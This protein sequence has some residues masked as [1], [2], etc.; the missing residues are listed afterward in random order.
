MNFFFL[1]LASLIVTCLGI[2]LDNDK[3]YNHVSDE[4]HHKLRGINSISKFNAFMISYKSVV[5]DVAKP[6][7][8]VLNLEK[9][10]RKC[11]DL[12]KPLL[13]LEQIIESRHENH[14]CGRAYIDRLVDFHFRYIT[15]KEASDDDDE[16]SRLNQK[17]SGS[18]Y[19]AYIFNLY[20][21]EVALTCKKRL[22]ERIRAL[23]DQKDCS[24][25]LY[26]F[27]PSMFTQSV[28]E[29][30]SEADMSGLANFLREF[31]RVENFAPIIK[32]KSA[33]VP[34]AHYDA[35]I[36]EGAVN[37]IEQLKEICKVRQPHYLA[38]FSPISRLAQ[39]GY[40][41]DENSSDSEDME[42]ADTRLLKC[43]LATAQL[44][45]GIL[46]THLI[47]K[48]NDE[49]NDELAANSKFVS[50]KW[51]PESKDDTVDDE[52]TS[53]TE[54][55]DSVDEIAPEVVERVNKHFTAA[56]KIKRKVWSW[57]KSFVE[58]HI[59]MEAMQT[60]ANEQFLDAL[61]AVDNGIDTKVAFSGRKFDDKRYNPL[62]ALS[63]YT[64]TV[65][66]MTASFWN[67]EIGLLASSVIGVT[68]SAVFVWFSIY[69]ATSAVKQHY[70]DPKDDANFKEYWRQLRN[71]RMEKV[72]SKVK[73]GKKFVPTP[74]VYKPI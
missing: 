33:H 74:T 15:K 17:I 25:V 58:R 19:I 7:K 9:R 73:K 28:S 22:I 41:M 69:A 8:G 1:Y 2:E 70:I 6:K 3:N 32:S 16:E 49:N 4:C 62:S 50:I 27:M 30:G 43:W 18:S 31:K 21:R 42:N 55:L 57:T 10:V 63:G 64:D 24:E 40:T 48:N 71:E 13:D 29:T 39:L 36:P 14:V 26:S 11:Y 53:S 60:E 46:R 5:R 66:Q 51:E 20:A 23:Q 59:D 52:S 72:E 56:G 34:K 45:E 68:L 47:V 12:E 38:L 37:K 44:C 67:K 54:Y 61:T 65:I 35:I